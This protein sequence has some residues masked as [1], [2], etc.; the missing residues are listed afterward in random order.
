MKNDKTYKVYL[1]D[2]GQS[3][4]TAKDPIQAAILVSA[5]RIRCDKVHHV[6][7]IEYGAEV[8]SGYL[9]FAPVNKLNQ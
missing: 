7:G 9:M 8:I 5:D 4:I 3:V 2:G 1:A 6:V